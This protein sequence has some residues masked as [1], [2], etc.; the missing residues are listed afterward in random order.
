[1]HIRLTKDTLSKARTTLPVGHLDETAQRFC[2]GLASSQQVNREV[3]DTAEYKHRGLGCARSPA[4]EHS[5]P[6]G[7]GAGIFSPPKLTGIV[8]TVSIVN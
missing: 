6:E 1:M 3:S 8:F 7:A 5:G 4:P 2:L